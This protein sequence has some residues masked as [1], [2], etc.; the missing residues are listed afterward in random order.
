MI[1]FD[2]GFSYRKDEPLD[3]RMDMQS[4][5]PAWQWIKDASEREITDVLFQFGEE[6]NARKIAYKLVQAALQEEPLT[7]NDLKKICV[8]AY[9]AKAKR[10]TLRHPYV[11][12]FQ[13][14]RIFIND[15][16]GALRT[17]LDL[18]PQ[19]L[20]KAGR[21]NVI[22]FHSLEDRMTKRTFRDL[23]Q[24]LDESPLARS[25]YKDGDFKV[26]TRKAIIADEQELSENSRSRSARM[27]ILE[28]R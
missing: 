28:K 12:S 27:R 8:G 9:A 18:A 1:I 11:K 4:G 16:L 22:S 24:I 13:A 19:L 15:E 26:I 17:F 20:R 14:I 5:I 21:L 23:S 6:S 2:R 25:N 3:M 10:H 7:T